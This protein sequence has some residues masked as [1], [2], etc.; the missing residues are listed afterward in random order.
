MRSGIKPN[1]WT[2]ETKTRSRLKPR[3]VSYSRLMTIYRKRMREFL[4]RNSGCAV[5]AG[6]PS[7]QV[8]HSR[9]RLKALL[10]DERFWVPVSAEGHQWIH[11][12]VAEAMRLGLMASRGKWNKQ[13]Q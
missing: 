1:G 9:G 12:H 2:V 4:K 10:L 11:S 13:P 6:K 8:H 5:F 3:S 7:S